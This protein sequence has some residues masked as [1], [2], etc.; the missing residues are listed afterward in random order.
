MIKPDSLPFKLSVQIPTDWTPEQAFA[1][2]ELIDNLRDAIWQ[3]YSV[4]LLDEYRD[5]FQPPVTDRPD[6]DPDDP[7]F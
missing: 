7:P 6:T 3:Y 4:P 1:A 5:R 2:F